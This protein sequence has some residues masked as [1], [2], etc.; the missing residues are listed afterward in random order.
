MKNVVMIC[1]GLLCSAPAFAE[2]AA[3]PAAPELAIGADAR[4]WL[5]LQKSPSAQVMNTPPVP[6]EVATEVYQRYV[7]SF[8]HPIPEK[9]SRES[10][11]QSGSS[12]GSSQ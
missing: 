8:K 10:Y 12:G 6:G 7:N 9:F 5:D 2:T 11:V 1:A 3:T 4:A